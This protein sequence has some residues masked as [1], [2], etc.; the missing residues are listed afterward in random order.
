M[1][2]VRVCPNCELKLER[3]QKEPPSEFARRRF[4]DRKCVNEWTRFKRPIA[5]GTY[6]GVKQHRA[7][8]EDPC[9]VCRPVENRY[10]QMKTGTAAQR[11][12]K[13]SQVAA[14][15]AAIAELIRR[16]RPEFL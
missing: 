6:A 8:G 4:C 15:N 2:Q 1:E 9:D 13:R 11:E 5:H 12:R 10:R 3:K 14:R 7:R 16:Y